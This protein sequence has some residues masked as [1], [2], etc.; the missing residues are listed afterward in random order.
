MPASLFYFPVLET[1]P[2]T[3][4][5]S[6]RSTA[7]DHYIVVSLRSHDD[8]TRRALSHSSSTVCNIPFHKTDVSDHIRGKWIREG[9]GESAVEGTMANASTRELLSPVL[10]T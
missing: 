2:E 1:E 8:H 4:G 5:F 9:A 7:P 6:H 3:Q 10:S